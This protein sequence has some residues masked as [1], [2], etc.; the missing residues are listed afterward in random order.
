MLKYGLHNRQVFQ[1]VKNTESSRS[2]AIFQIKLYSKAEEMGLNGTGYNFMDE[3]YLKYGSR[4][5]GSV[6]GQ[7]NLK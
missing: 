6:Y 7:N 1:T 3:M 2:H 5:G 4:Y